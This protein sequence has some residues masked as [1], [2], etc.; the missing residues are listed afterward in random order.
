MIAPLTID[1][2]AIMIPSKSHPQREPYG[3]QPIEPQKVQPKSPS[4]LQVIGLGFLNPATDPKSMAIYF[5]AS[6][7]V[8]RAVTS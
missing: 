5:P 4:M 2:T 7:K 1:E 8:K 3:T 6:T